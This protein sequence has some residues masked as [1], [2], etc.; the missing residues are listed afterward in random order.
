MALEYPD[1][2]TAICNIAL[3]RLGSRRITSVDPSDGSPNA[4]YC[5]LHLPRAIEDVLAYHDWIGMTKRVG[6]EKS[7]GTPANGF[8]YFYQQPPD[9]ERILEVV[10]GGV[11][12]RAEQD[13]ILTDAETVDLAYIFRPAATD[14]VTIPKTIRAAI[15]ATLAFLLTTPLTSSEQLAN[16][17]AGEMATAYTRALAA[18][19]KGRE[20]DDAALQ[21]GFVW[22][23]ELR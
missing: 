2:W 5:A 19:G 22:Y 8:L 17:I 16:R 12:F 4:S 9:L 7:T 20:P 1:S 6:L 21:L 23:D 18:D 10:T 13:Q 11:P 3:G 14:I 15:S